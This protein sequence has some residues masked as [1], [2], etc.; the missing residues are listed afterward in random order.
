MLLT[1]K[2]SKHTHTHPV[3]LEGVMED[4]RVKTAVK[5]VQAVKKIK[6]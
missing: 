1:L 5:A 6:K 2:A 4:E 3:E